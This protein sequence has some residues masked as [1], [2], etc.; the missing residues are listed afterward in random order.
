M[1]T[2]D[3]RQRI[4]TII[5]HM[6]DNYHQIF[7]V[8]DELRSEVEKEI[9]LQRERHQSRR[10][11]CQRVSQE[12]YQS[13]RESVAQTELSEL[14]ENIVRDENMSIKAKKQRLKQVLLIVTQH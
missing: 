9:E 11:Y 13:Q 8:S 1:I 14:L 3:I 12:V 5:R 7:K 4:V 6:V 10:S 2:F